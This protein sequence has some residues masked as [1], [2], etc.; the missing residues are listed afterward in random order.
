MRRFD[1]YSLQISIITKDHKFFKRIPLRES[2]LK[3]KTTFQPVFISRKLNE[4]L[5]FREVKPAIV[6]QQCAMQDIL[7]ILAATSTNALMDTNRN[8]RQF[9][10]II[11]AN[12][13]RTYHLFFQ[14][15]FTCSL[16]VLT[17]LIA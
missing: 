9:V 7:V 4:D 1:F 5:K 8:H 11:L 13:T 16:K 15:N 2:S 14:N 10:N 17:N 3:I 6:N 12:I